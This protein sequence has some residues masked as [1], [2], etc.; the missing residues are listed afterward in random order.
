MNGQEERTQAAKIQ[1]GRLW[2][3]GFDFGLIKILIF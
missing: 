3:C 1:E 2:K